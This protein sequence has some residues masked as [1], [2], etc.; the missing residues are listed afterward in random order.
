MPPNPPLS[1][2]AA[3]PASAAYASS[4]QPKVPAGGPRY[5]D[6]R[7]TVRQV[8]EIDRLKAPEADGDTLIW[9][10]GASLAR[11][12]ESNRELLASYQWNLA[13]RPVREWLQARLAGPLVA[14]AGHQPDFFHPGVW[15]KGVAAAFLSRRMRGSAQFLL[16]DSDVPNELAIRWPTLDDNE[17][18]MQR[19]PL[20]DS[21]ADRAFEHLPAVSPSFWGQFV[22]RLDGANTWRGEHAFEAFV[23]GFG[24]ENL[25]SFS[26]VDQWIE[27]VR[28]VDR[29]LEIESPEFIRVSEIFSSSGDQRDPAAVAFAAHVIVCADALL[30]AYNGSLAEYRKRRGVRGNQHPIPDLIVEHGRTELP[31]WVIGEGQPRHRLF[32]SRNGAGQL[33][34]WRGGQ[35]VGAADTEMFTRDPRAALERALGGWQIRP[36]ALA[37]TIYARLLACDLFIHGIGGANYDQV[38]DGIIRRFF[39]VEPPRFAC[40]SATARLPLEYALDGEAERAARLRRIRDMRFN[41]QR[42]VEEGSLSGSLNGQA[43]ARA[44]AVEESARLRAEQ[45]HDRQARRAVYQRIHRARRELFAAIEHSEKREHQALAALERRLEKARVAASREWF[46]ALYPPQALKSLGDRIIG[47]LG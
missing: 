35:V 12:T 16:V 36:R 11:I 34:L 23:S 5:Y 14:M 33:E 8:N 10:G 27:G 13:G 32:V 25:A 22:G 19:A 15:A 28:A 20:F 44:Q 45:R 7:M 37:L 31:F 41:P 38:A 24:A 1:P 4:P 17:R 46:F 21:L 47:G 40:V 9:P 43:L 29:A 30:L 18:L 3:T 26:Y 6:T 39:G 2:I 42:Y